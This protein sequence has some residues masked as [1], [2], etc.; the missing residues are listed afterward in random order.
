MQNQPPETEPIRC[1]LGFRCFGDRCPFFK[2]G[3]AWV[4]RSGEV[5]SFDPG[6]AIEVPT[7]RLFGGE[8]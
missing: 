8:R 1:P 4:D 7:C 5:L 3:G 2:D 6:R